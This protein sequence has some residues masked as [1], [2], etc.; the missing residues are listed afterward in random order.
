MLNFTNYNVS[1]EP[2]MQLVSKYDMPS[3]AGYQLL[4][5][6]YLK[7]D[8]Y[9]NKSLLLN[10]WSPT[11]KTST[12]IDLKNQSVVADNLKFKILRQRVFRY[13]IC[14]I[15]TDDKETEQRLACFNPDKMSTQTFGRLFEAGSSKATII[16]DN[17]TCT[18]DTTGQ[19]ATDI[20][21]T[22]VFTCD[23]NR[24]LIAS[25]EDYRAVFKDEFVDFSSN[26]SWTSFTYIP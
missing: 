16:F 9:K 12:L 20:S 4:D 6:L 15:M 22:A 5:I 10:Y 23:N 13:L 7:K 1:K 2:S 19:Y 26:S 8:A 21:Q 25:M 24:R 11:D 14:F 18:A 3:L 17:Q